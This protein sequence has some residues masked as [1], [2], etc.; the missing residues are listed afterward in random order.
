M[1][2]HFSRIFYKGVCSCDA[3]YIVETIRNFS[4]RQNEYES[5]TDK[6][7]ECFKHLQEHFSHEFQRSLLS[8]TLRKIP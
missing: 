5:G 7:L 8:I 6:N 4:I 2:Q 1:V 3:D